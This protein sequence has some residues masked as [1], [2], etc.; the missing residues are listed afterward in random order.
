MFACIQSRF[1]HTSRYIDIGT[2][3]Q[4]FVEQIVS[5]LFVRSCCSSFVV[6]SSLLGCCSCCV[7]LSDWTRGMFVRASTGTFIVGI[8][9]NTFCCSVLCLC[10]NRTLPRPRTKTAIAAPLLLDRSLLFFLPFFFF[11]PFCC[12][13]N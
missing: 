5:V 4:P 12:F 6:S 11:A 13:P 3:R 7:P 9:G 1:L 8:A 2:N 10:F